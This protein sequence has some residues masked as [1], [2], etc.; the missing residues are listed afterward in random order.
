MNPAEEVESDALSQSPELQTT[1]AA[2]KTSV[3]EDTPELEPHFETFAPSPSLHRRLTPTRTE[4]EPHFETFGASPSLHQIT[5]PTTTTTESHFETFGASPDLHQKTTPTADATVVEGDRRPDPPF[6]RAAHMDT[7]DVQTWEKI[8]PQRDFLSTP[9]L[10]KKFLPPSKFSVLKSDISRLASHTMDFF[11]SI[12][13]S[14]TMKEILR[15]VLFTSLLFLAFSL[16]GAPAVRMWSQIS[17]ERDKL[18]LEREKLQHEET[19]ERLRGLRT[20]AQWAEEKSRLTALRQLE[21]DRLAAIAASERAIIAV[22]LEA[23]NEKERIK[24]WEK[25][26]ASPRVTTKKGWWSTEETRYNA[27]EISVED[28]K[29]LGTESFHLKDLEHHLL[30]GLQPSTEKFHVDGVRDTS[31]HNEAPLEHEYEYKDMYGHLKR[32]Y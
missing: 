1:S 21:S 24:A 16:I 6:D 29:R 10:T 12:S 13:P 8:Q 17:T 5:T 25:I 14:S 27:A 18:Q 23:E 7:D 28:L 11:R 2:S 3:S 15:L 26:M 9:D 19:M 30:A 31:H 22:K 32:V 20:S 4:T